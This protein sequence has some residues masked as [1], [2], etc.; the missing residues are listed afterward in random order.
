MAEHERS[1]EEQGGSLLSSDTATL[2]L[3]VGR[4]AKE[5]FQART[6]VHG[7]KSAEGPQVTSRL[8]GRP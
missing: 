5:K 2:G 7:M 1:E 3:R 6:L 8:S 4:K